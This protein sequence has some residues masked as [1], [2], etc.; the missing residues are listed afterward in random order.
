MD[1]MIA[2]AVLS[3]TV[4]GASGYRY[5]AAIDAR[6]ATEQVT[7]A[8]VALLLCESWRGI[9][10][11]ETYDP[12]AYLA[13]D[14]TIVQITESI[15]LGWCDGSDDEYDNNDGFTLLGGY[16]ITIENTNYCA[17]LAYKDVSSEL[18]ALNAVIGWSQDG[19]TIADFLEDNNNLFRLTTY[20][21]R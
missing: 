1:T 8:R 2:I 6:R 3:I 14:L 7:A 13:S 11:D 9:D 5:H 21:L 17:I 20:A 15:Q 12:A 19:Q 18:R 16:L 4:L 10:G